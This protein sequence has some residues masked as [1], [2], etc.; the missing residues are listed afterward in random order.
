MK[1]LI[2][3]ISLCLSLPA[4][5][6]TVRTVVST[7]TNYTIAPTAYGIQ[8]LTN[9]D[10]GSVLSLIGAAGLS[11]NNVFTGTMNV[12]GAVTLTN[13]ASVFIGTFTGDGSG[14][15]NVTAT[16]TGYVTNYGGALTNGQFYGST[17]NGPTTNSSLTASRV[18]I[19]NAGGVQTNSSVTDTELGYVSGVTS[20]IQT[21][22]DSKPTVALT[23]VALLNTSQTFTGTPTFPPAML[24]ANNVG[25]RLLASSPTNIYIDSVATATAATNAGDFSRVSSVL[26]ATIPPLAGSNSS[27]LISYYN[28]RTNAN[29][30]NIVYGVWAGANTNYVGGV[31]AGTT[32]A[33]VSGVNLIPIIYN[34]NSLTNQVGAG[35]SI[36]SIPTY[37][38]PTNLFDSS[39]TNTIYIG[40]S[41]PGG[42]HTN[43]QWFGVRLYELYAP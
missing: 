33:G 3:L 36:V 37:S 6:A 13:G 9:S 1:R 43:E 39:V 7:T 41:I 8:L 15:S 20:A 18:M 34:A 35:Q 27:I 23:N 26:Q 38:T 2:L 12:T 32:S 31:S 28:V 42:T 5:S 21:Q 25:L 30:T 4:Y 19:L 14:L 11:S 17:L 29:L 22:L 24:S 16:V 10:A 40:V